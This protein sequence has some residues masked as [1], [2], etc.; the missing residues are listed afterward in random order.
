[1]CYVE[2]GEESWEAER[3]L[4]F[5][6]CQRSLF[7]KHV[8]HFED[9][10]GTGNAPVPLR[11]LHARDEEICGCQESKTRLILRAVLEEELSLLPRPDT[12]QVL[13]AFLVE[14]YANVFPANLD[15]VG[16]DQAIGCT[17]AGLQAND[18]FGRKPVLEPGLHGPEMDRACNVEISSCSEKHPQELSVMRMQ[19]KHRQLTRRGPLANLVPGL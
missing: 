9:R 4:R 7:V 14:E 2:L 19:W 10:H 15:R 13:C 5:G 16:A 11:F 12:E 6:I 8:E 1:M 17:L 3:E 18:V